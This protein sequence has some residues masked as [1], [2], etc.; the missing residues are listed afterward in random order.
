MAISAVHIIKVLAI[1]LAAMLPTATPDA[2]RPVITMEY[3]PPR[4]DSPFWMQAAQN[5]PPIDSADFTLEYLEYK[6]C[7]GQP[8][9]LGDEAAPLISAIERK[10]GAMSLISCE[11]RLF[12]GEDKEYSNEEIIIGTIPAGP[13]GVDV[14]ETMLVIG[15]EWRTARGIRVGSTLEEV[16][17]AYGGEPAIDWNQIVYS[18]GDPATSPVIIFQ[19][20]DGAVAA[21]FLDANTRK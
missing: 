18:N 8:Y 20:K 2:A 9:A 7:E 10:M 15:G 14:I 21:F 6:E 5:A 16:A 13:G 11:A 19:V 1:I 4:A 12:P 17:E 3:A